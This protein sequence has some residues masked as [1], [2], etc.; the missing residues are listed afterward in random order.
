MVIQDVITTVTDGIPRTPDWGD[1]HRVVRVIQML[2]Q[3][4][5]KDGATITAQADELENRSLRL[6]AAID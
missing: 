2:Y 3:S 6:V 5:E 1:G 4:Q